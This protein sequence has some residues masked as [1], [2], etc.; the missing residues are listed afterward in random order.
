MLVRALW[1]VLKS[2][3]SQTGRCLQ[4]LIHCLSR[5]ILTENIA[6]LKALAR[7]TGFLLHL[8]VKAS[9]VRG[10]KPS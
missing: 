10:A 7:G 4:H 5:R 2:G 3:N 8:R 9:R 6:M 1:H